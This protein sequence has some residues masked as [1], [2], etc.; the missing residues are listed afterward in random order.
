MAEHKDRKYIGRKFGA[1]HRSRELAVQFLYSLDMCPEQDFSEA[2]ELFLSLDDVTQD[3]KPEVKTRCREMVRQVRDRKDEIDGALVRVVTGWRP[4]R[5]VTVDRAILRLML[6][7]GFIL[8]TLPVKSAI[9]EAVNLASSFGTKN[10]PRFVNGV[11]HRAA[12]FFGE[13]VSESAGD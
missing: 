13:G 4:E 3:D 10:S 7:E 12:E 2:L 9:A 8:K 5:M 11:M 6:L 1:L